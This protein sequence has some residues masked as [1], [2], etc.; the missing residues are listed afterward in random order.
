MGLNANPLTK[1]VK[2]AWGLAQKLAQNRLW[3]RGGITEKGGKIGQDISEGLTKKVGQNGCAIN[4][5]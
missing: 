1:L 2:M 4:W 5:G 3:A